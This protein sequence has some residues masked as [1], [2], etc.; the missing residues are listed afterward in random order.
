MGYVTKDL[1]KNK[2]KRFSNILKQETTKKIT[3]SKKFKELQNYIKKQK[4]CENKAIFENI[5][6]SI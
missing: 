6:K 5:N 3:S 4:F 1:K 2:T